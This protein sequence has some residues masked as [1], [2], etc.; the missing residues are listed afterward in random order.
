MLF[1]VDMNSDI[2]LRMEYVDFFNFLEMFRNMNC[3][4]FIG[5]NLI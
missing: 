1:Y 3:F 2:S 4:F 5:W